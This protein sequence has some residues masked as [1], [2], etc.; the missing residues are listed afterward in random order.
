M[1]ELCGTMYASKTLN[2]YAFA[3]TNGFQK[4]MYYL[5]ADIKNF[6]V[7]INRDILYKLLCRQVTEQWLLDLLYLIV[8][9][10]CR[11]NC[12]L[13]SPKWK[14]DLI[15]DYKS[16]WN[17]ADNKGLPIGNLT[18][19]FFSNV[20]L[21][22]LDQYVK[23]HWHCKYYCRYVDDFVIFDENPQK[24]N[25]IHKDLTRFL[26]EH[27]DLELHRHKKSINKVSRGVDFVGYVTKPNRTMMRQKTI[28]RIFKRIREY[29][30]SENWY[31]SESIEAFVRSMNSY[32][33]LLRNINGYNLRKKIC[34]SCVNL[35]IGCDE[36]YT[37]IYSNFNPPLAKRKK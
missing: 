28:K 1:I 25:E 19:Q 9:N 15:P 34:L 11:K 26:K 16:L 5:K 6:F 23:H 12:I 37:K 33:G 2:N 30:N 3:I 20:Y 17:A 10:D 7:S 32:I 21:N 18:S 24:L 29:Y 35:F 8:Y 27:L 14:F 36:E 4:E 13:H 31:E 22:E